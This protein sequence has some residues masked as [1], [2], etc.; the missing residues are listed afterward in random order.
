MMVAIQVMVV[1]PTRDMI[2]AFVMY[3]YMYVR[4]QVWQVW[5]FGHVE[6]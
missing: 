5:P 1:I 6:L 3:M 2:H 4:W